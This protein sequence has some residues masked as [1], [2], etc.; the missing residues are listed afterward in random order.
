MRQIDPFLFALLAV[1]AILSALTSI[2]VPLFEGPDEDDHFRYTKY[3]ADHRALPV[4]LF[5]QGGGEAG[6]QGWQ[7]PLYYGLAALVISP[8]DTSDYLER[9]QRNPAAALDGDLACCGRNNYFHLGAEDFPY[10]N[11]T[12]AVHLAR[13][14]TILFGLACVYAVYSLVLTLFYEQRYLALATTAIATRNSPPPRT[15]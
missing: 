10:R 13:V 11:T 4:Q 9:L 8:V 1:F 15:R 5:Q 14:V 3:I 12:L 2:L 7:P 6:H